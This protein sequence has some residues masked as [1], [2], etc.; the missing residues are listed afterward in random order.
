MSFENGI[1]MAIRPVRHE[2]KCWLSPGLIDLQ[3]NGYGGEDVN[4]EDL[5]TDTI[6]RLTEKMIA[7]GVTT[8]L[9]TIITSSETKITATLRTIAEARARYPVVAN[10]IPCVHVE[11]PHISPV[12]GP[13]GA[14][15]QEHVRRPDIAEFNR[16]QDASAGLV[17]MITL[18]PHFAEA[19]EYIA[20]VT[21][22]GVVVALGH[23]DATSEEIRKAVNAGARLST[24]LGNGI[25][26][27]LP[28]HPNVVWTQL[29]DDRLSATMIADGHHL[30]PDTLKVMVRA[31]GVS[32]SILV[33]DTV[34]VA[35]KTPGIYQTPVGGCVE[36]H[37]DGRLSLAGTAYLAG[38]V[39]PLKDGV[40]HACRMASI[41][42]SEA[43]TMATVNPGRFVGGRGV[44]KVGSPADLI[45][46]TLD[47]ATM[48]LHIQTTVVGG[49]VRNLTADH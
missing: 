25:G 19:E 11:G 7:T 16:W 17:G 18:S 24:H 23:T 14:H 46:F 10:V 3:V 12:D 22:R 8:F 40:A 6:L 47:E 45:Q 36:L 34:G 26:A 9:P 28:R 20:A 13:R 31:K 44:L 30:P 1:V 5:D 27:T 35:G 2:E 43:L 33:S 29:A 37:A 41:S 48:E 21:K 32:R 42:L 4:A 15:P 39:L 49:S 38:A